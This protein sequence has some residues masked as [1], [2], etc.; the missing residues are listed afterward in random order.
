MHSFTVNL[1]FLNYLHKYKTLSYKLTKL[2]TLALK[3]N[4]NNK[5]TLVK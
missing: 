2:R 4:K 1:F 3:I 5:D